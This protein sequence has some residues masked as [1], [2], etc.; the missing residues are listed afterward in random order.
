[1]SLFGL[2]EERIAVEV[3]YSQT[4]FHHVRW[5]KVPKYFLKYMPCH[6]MPHTYYSTCTWTWTQVWVFGLSWVECWMS[7]AKLG[8]NFWLEWTRMEW[9]RIFCW[10]WPWVW[11]E[12][13]SQ[14]AVNFVCFV[15]MIYPEETKERNEYVV[16]NRE[17]ER[18]VLSELELFK[19]ESLVYTSHQLLH[20]NT[21]P[22]HNLTL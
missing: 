7:L 8:E 9:K 1:M 15:I 17:K 2:T 13:V 14:T 11:M 4:D 16:G 5:K 22:Y 19:L 10:R 20:R 3:I 6:A 12:C 18:M 21:I